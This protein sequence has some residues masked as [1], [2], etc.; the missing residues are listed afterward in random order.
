MNVQEI[1][2]EL[3]RLE[4]PFLSPDYDPDIERYF[5]LR[6][7][8]R[9][10]DALVLYQNR[11][12]PR[13]PQD[14]F[15]ALLMR[16]YRS[17]DPSYKLIQAKA[18]RNLGERALERIKKTIVYIVEKVES[19][20]EKDV[21]ST[22]KAADE[23]LLALP[24]DHYEAQTGIE[25]LLH[26]A[27]ELDFYVK[28]M[29]K[30]ADLI[31]SYLNQSLSVVEEAKNRRESQ[32]Q[33]ALEREQQ[34]QI[35]EDWKSYSQQKKQGRRMSQRRPM[36]DLTAIEFAQEDLARIEIPGDMIKPEDQTLA[37]C[38]KY[39]NLIYDSAFE[40]ILYFY[41]KKYGTKHHAVFLAIR[42]G[43][44][45]QFRDDEILASVMSIL[46]TG[47]YYSIR[48]DVYLQ[49]KWNSIKSALQQHASKEG[50]RRIRPKT[51]APRIAFRKTRS[52]RNMPAGPVKASKVSPTASPSVF[53][54]KP[55]KLF[56]IAA[57]TPAETAGKAVQSQTAPALN[58]SKRTLPVLPRAKTSPVRSRMRT[59]AAS[60][61]VKAPV[62]AKAAS[63]PAQPLVRAKAASG[64]AQPPVRAKAASGP[65]QPLVRA[66]AASGPAQP[67]VRA[68]AASGPAQ[69]PV[70]AKAA[71]GPVQPLVR[72]KA[73]SGPA[74]PLVRAKAGS[75]PAQPLVRAKAAS[76]PAQ[77]SVR[78][79][80]ASGP[81]QPLV[82]AK[83]ASGPAQPLVRA[84]AVP[85]PAKPPAQQEK[86]IP[87]SPQP[88]RRPSGPQN[89]PSGS[90]SDRLRE[91]SGRSY[92]V[93]Q[94]RFL[95]RV[96]GAIRKVMGS[97]KRLFFT[98]P[99]AAED[100]V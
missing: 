42:R 62:R 57:S 48:G 9:P 67:P 63:G 46:V 94:D 26:Y 68:K 6:S 59:K 96:R 5:Y 50:T 60:N 36:I 11:L 37:Y 84:K 78:A 51:T 61:L 20:N 41:S 58:R 35:R 80:A 32:R 99:G 24:K 69:P 19:Y 52:R 33:Q 10:Q 49:R 95:S 29:T 22:I 23:I 90:V 56:R 83:A 86:I 75:G 12:K 31:R 70:R 89:Q 92:D 30:A 72:A 98:L 21:F 1:Q 28:S 25:R 3:L 8:H 100:L 53:R 79:K 65:A 43:R 85:I 76:G 13:Y 40:Q 16:C 39:W 73:A 4:Y 44:I 15:R 81:A 77:P 45:N 87:P 82:R 54:R 64:P 14:E 38:V 47:Y 74:Q 17:R 93:Y 18:Y 7:S 91:L 55:R 66:K 2:D 97:G 27:E 71:S 88:I 34:R